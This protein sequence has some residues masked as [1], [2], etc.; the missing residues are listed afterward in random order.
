MT[1]AFLLELFTNQSVNCSRC[2]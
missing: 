1:K 2:N